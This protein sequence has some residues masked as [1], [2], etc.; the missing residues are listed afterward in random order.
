MKKVMTRKSESEMFP[1]I[2]EWESSDENRE[3]FCRRHN[4]SLS[5]FSYWRTRYAKSKIG[6]TAHQQGKFIEL[7]PETFEDYLEILY[8]NGVRLRLPSGSSLSSLQTLIGLV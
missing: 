2:E 3:A 4:V 7:S 1:I 6:A 5:T 8:P